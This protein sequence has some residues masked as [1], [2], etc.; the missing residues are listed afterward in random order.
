MR[1]S[2]LVGVGAVCALRDDYSIRGWFSRK[3]CISRI[4]TR[5][6]ASDAR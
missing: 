4:G 1:L 6:K 3:V 2:Q 5:H